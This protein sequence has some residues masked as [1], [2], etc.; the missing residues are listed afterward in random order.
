MSNTLLSLKQNQE[1]AFEQQE[2]TES[3]LKGVVTSGRKKYKQV[4]DSLD[5][6][7]TMVS[8]NCDHCGNLVVMPRYVWLKKMRNGIKMTFCN[9]EC[10]HRY[11]ARKCPCGKPT[12]KS[13]RR[14]CSAEC[15]KKYGFSG[16]HFKTLPDSVCPEC[17][18]L[19]H[20]RSHRT[21]YCSRECANKAHSKRMVGKGNS[22][23]KDGTS[24]ALLF[25]L[26]SKIVAERDAH[27][28]VACNS[29]ATNKTITWRKKQVTR[30]LMV[31]HHIDHDTRNNRPE[32]L[33][34]LCATCHSI[35]HKSRPSPF[36]WFGKYGTEATKSMTYKLKEQSAS[37]LTRFLSTTAG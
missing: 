12:G 14:F 31:V 37:L 8:K 11:M 30:S 18:E 29:E 19:F 15:R 26:M 2:I 21:Q 32:N 9:R 6:R 20:P 22:H 3:S 27:Q 17:G 35:H 33:I 10:H 34:Y 23:F 24:Y 1:S 25:N 16:A 5:M 4:T 13:Q 28:C 7:G 36:D